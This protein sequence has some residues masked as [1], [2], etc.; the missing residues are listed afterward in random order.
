MARNK[1]RVVLDTNV[2]VSAIVFGGTP[3]E[4][5][6]LILKEEFIGVTSISL[7]AELSE[8]VHKKFSFKKPDLEY[9]EEQ[10]NIDFEV[11]KPRNSVRSARDD[12]D[13]RVLEAAIT[14]ECDYIITGDEDLLVLKKYKNIR[15]LTPKEF[16]SSIVKL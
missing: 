9:L 2:L 14:G 15:I 11:V 1:T 8:V 13:N 4:V 5:L 3:K 6:N 16:L 7:M 12:D 10:I